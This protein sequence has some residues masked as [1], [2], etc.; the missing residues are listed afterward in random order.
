MRRKRMEKRSDTAFSCGV[1][2]QDPRGKSGIRRSAILLV[3]MSISDSISVEKKDYDFSKFFLPCDVKLF[4]TIV[5]SSC[6]PLKVSLFIIKRFNRF[7]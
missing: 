3:F 1:C 5:Q 2:F 7:W 4:Q 6:I